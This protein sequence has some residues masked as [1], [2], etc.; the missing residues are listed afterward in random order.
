MSLL[1]DD[2]GRTASSA[3]RAR[4]SST[5]ARV[6]VPLAAS[7]A[8]VIL[9]VAVTN[10]AGV[11]APAIVGI[12]IVVALGAAVAARRTLGSL[13]AGA[14]LLLVRPYYRGEQ[15]RLYVP[16][17]DSVVDAEVVR[18]GPANTTLKTS[19]RLVVVPNSW[20]LRGDPKHPDSSG[21]ADPP[22]S[23]G[24]SEPELSE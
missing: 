21:P 18:V 10:L 23:S 5:P 6:G 15:V 12:A 8:A 2:A 13:A 20:M 7:S 14:G 17:L 4:A 24:K 11:A 3:R 19:H 9:S 16:T 22:S 1:R